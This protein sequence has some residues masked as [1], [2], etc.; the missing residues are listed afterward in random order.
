L[1]QARYDDLQVNPLQP[2]AS[3]GKQAT[4]G[5][6]HRVF[7]YLASSKIKKALQ[8]NDFLIVQVDTDCS[9]DDYYDVPQTKMEGTE[10]VARSIVE[11]RSAV[12]ERLAAVIAANHGAT[13]AAILERTLFAI[14][15]HSLEC[16]LLVK[17]A[18]EKG[19]GR[20]KNCHQHL[21]RGLK[22]SIL[23]DHGIYD[24]LTRDWRKPKHLNEAAKQNPSLALFL[25]ELP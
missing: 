7:E 13:T 17:V 20:T 14:A 10:V 12:R 5:G 21:E 1:L 9:Q 11:L 23:K 18:A 24:E 22:R 4:E 8:V 2:L 25:D 19:K 15:V 6:W 3:E 16:W